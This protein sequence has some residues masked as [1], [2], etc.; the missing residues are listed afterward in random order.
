M[1]TLLVI[2][3]ISAEIAAYFTDRSY[4][5]AIKHVNALKEKG[6]LGAAADIYL[7]LLDEEYRR[8]IHRNGRIAYLTDSV[9]PLLKHTG[10]YDRER[11]ILE[12]S[13]KICI[14]DTRSRS[15]ERWQCRLA[16]LDQIPPK[17]CTSEK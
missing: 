15:W 11:E 17:K 16:E 13:M 6:D 10:R 9:Q 2:L 1:L 12:R 4:K 5:D 8:K 7:N 14:A 3:I